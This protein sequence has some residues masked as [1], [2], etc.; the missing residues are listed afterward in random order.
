[1]KP[2][3]HDIAN[4]AGVSLSTVDR[5]LNGRAG[6]RAPTRKRVQDIIDQLG[7]VR[8]PAAVNLAKGRVYTLTFI[9]P[10]NDNSFMQALRAEIAEARERGA[11]ERVQIVLVTVPAFDAEALGLAIRSAV[12]TGPDGIALVAIDDGHVRAAVSIAQ[13]AGIPVVTLVSDLPGSG[14]CHFAGI[15]NEAAG[16]TAAALIGRFLDGREGSVGIIA[17]SLGVRDHR[18]RFDGFRQG[19][20]RDFPTLTTLPVIEGLDEPERVH[21]LTARLIAD[22]PDLIGIYSLGAGNR[23]LI[24]ALGERQGQNPLRVIAHE[25]TPH[26]RQALADGLIDV[27]L[28]QDAGHEVRSAIRVLKARADGQSVIEGQERIRID[29]FL[30]DNLP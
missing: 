22:H 21:A 25:L 11:S 13:E 12:E 2:T 16:R 7:F 1:M 15:D 8:D 3:V 6:V 17:G 5:V 30:K 9:V 24:R 29:I 20:G 28:N 4:L 14:R 19:L 26:T 10:S 23:G 27:I 18:E